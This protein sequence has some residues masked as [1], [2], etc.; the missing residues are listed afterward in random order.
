[1]DSVGVPFDARA[2]IK[3]AMCVA[4]AKTSLTMTS[5]YDLPTV[6][7]TEFLHDGEIWQ[8]VM[9]ITKDLPTDLLSFEFENVQFG[10][11]CTAEVAITMKSLDITGSDPRIRG[12]LIQHIRTM[13]VSYFAM[14]QLMQSFNVARVIHFNEYSMLLG[15][16]L[17][18][19]RSGVPSTLLSMASAM[20][21]DRRKFVLMHENSAIASYRKRLARWPEWRNLC[22]PA[23]RVKEIAEDTLFRF[24]ASSGFVY[25]PGRTGSLQKIYDQLDLAR[26]RR[27]LVAFTS[28]LDEVAANVQYLSALGLEP[29]SEEQPFLDQVEWLKV[30]TEHVEASPDLQLVVRVHPR[31]GANALTKG[32]S[33]HMKILQDNF[34]GVYKHVRFIWPSDKI[35]SYDLMEMAEVGLSAWSSTSLELARMGVPSVIAFDRHTPL[36]VGDVVTWGHDRKAY[37]RAL[38]EALARKPSLDQIRFAYRWTNLHIRGASIDVGDI[39]PDANFGALPEY[40]TPSAAPII[41]DVLV[42]GRNLIEINCGILQQGGVAE[43]IEE[44]ALMQE[45]RGAVWFLTTGRLPAHDYRLYYGKPA[46]LGIPQ[47]YDAVIFADGPITE[48]RTHASIICRPSRMTDRIGSLCAHNTME[49][50]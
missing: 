31:E 39:V 27:L 49:K 22:L 21:V 50:A 4:C 30:L 7:L 28:S 15:A 3:N 20:G 13:L 34:S 1:M 6:E 46:D 9:T 26:E 11:I 29:F 38:G 14:Q 10:K 40:R 33:D 25:S 42:N 16:A 17:A 23:S 43:R 5:D 2:Q 8:K 12:F 24:S 47:G 32:S 41:E 36:P 18:A 37:F 19:R 45:L 35:S 44:K 48:F